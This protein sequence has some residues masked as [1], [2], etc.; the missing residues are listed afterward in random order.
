[1]SVSRRRDANLAKSNKI[2]QNRQK[3]ENQL[4]AQAK[5]Q[6]CTKKLNEKNEN[7][8]LAQARRKSGFFREPRKSKKIGPGRAKSERL[9]QARRKF[10]KMEQKKSWHFSRAPKSRNERLAQAR[11]SLLRVQGTPQKRPV[12][13]A[14]RPKW[15][16][17]VGET[18]IFRKSLKTA[19]MRTRVLPK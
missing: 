16:F 12:K 11:R 15:P 5:R 10:L 3:H 19:K 17:G 7:E 13:Q 18:Q 6:V 9:A 14:S 1:M 8:R 2:Q 4:L